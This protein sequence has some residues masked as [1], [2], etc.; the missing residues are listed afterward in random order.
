M[1]QVELWGKKKRRNQIGSEEITIQSA[2]ES[3]FYP[4]P[5]SNSQQI[6]VKSGPLSKGQLKIY[7][8]DHAPTVDVNSIAGFWLQLECIIIDKVSKNVV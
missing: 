4:Q 3:S 1:D 5:Q 8:N 6:L 7:Q 2:H